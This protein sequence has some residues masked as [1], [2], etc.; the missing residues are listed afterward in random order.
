MVEDTLELRETLDGAESVTR[1][2][3]VPER[4]YLLTE[5]GFHWINEFPLNR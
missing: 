3:R 5:R 4:G 2:E 1:L